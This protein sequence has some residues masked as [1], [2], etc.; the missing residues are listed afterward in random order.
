M[1]NN[2]EK[3]IEELKE[4]MAI[5]EETITRPDETTYPSLVITQI[6]RAMLG[7]RGA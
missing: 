2:Q 7:G 5:R 3:R 4:K 1:D 6:G